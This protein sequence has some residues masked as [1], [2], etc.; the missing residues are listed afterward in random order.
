M[1]TIFYGSDIAMLKLDRN[2]KQ[3][4]PRLYREGMY[5]VEE[6]DVPSTNWD[7]KR[8]LRA[9]SKTPT[10]S[11]TSSTSSVTVRSDDV[12]QMQ[13]EIISSKGW[14]CASESAKETCDGAR[15]DCALRV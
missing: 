10:T 4:V 15:T 8:R 1:G 5:L 12:C 14:L 13:R 3:P 11:A 6:L 2:A 7:V 9:M